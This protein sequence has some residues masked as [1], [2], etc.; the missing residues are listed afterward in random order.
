M[1]NKSSKKENNMMTCQQLASEM[2]HARGYVELLE[3]PT[4]ET[5]ALIHAL[6][7]AKRNFA[8]KCNPSALALKDDAVKA[9]VS[10]VKVDVQALGRLVADDI[11]E[12]SISVANKRIAYLN[13]V[14]KLLKHEQSYYVS[15]G[16]SLAD[17]I[18][19]ALE[20]RVSESETS[21]NDALESLQKS[22]GDKTSGRE[23]PSD[24]IFGEQF[25]DI[26]VNPSIGASNY[27]PKPDDQIVIMGTIIAILL[28]L[29]VVCLMIRCCKSRGRSVRRRK[30]IDNRCIES[31]LSDA[32]GV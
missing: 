6:K 23:G 5:K 9:D 10:D 8:A 20:L 14:A 26:S 22:P 32:I 18:A 2:F 19:S 31:D 13:N 29:N 25:E 11:D 24:F 3:L 21:D 4:D 30:H 27:Y 12:E 17:E 28:F 16:T 15:D 1:E 7:D